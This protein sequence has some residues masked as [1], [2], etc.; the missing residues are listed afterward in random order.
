MRRW[1]KLRIILSA[2]LIRMTYVD[3]ELL[4]RYAI[5]LWGAECEKVWI[6]VRVDYLMRTFVCFVVVCVC[7]CALCKHYIHGTSPK[8][9]AV[10]ASSG[11]GSEQLAH[12]CSLYEQFY[13]LSSVMLSAWPLSLLHFHFN[14]STTQIFSLIHSSSRLKCQMGTSKRLR[15]SGKWVDCVHYLCAVCGIWGMVSILTGLTFIDA[16]SAD[17]KL[18]SFLS[19]LL[20]RWI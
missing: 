12:L 18:V 14:I 17:G 3:C 5:Y 9:K 13:C 16:N 15:H 8:H 11:P 20:Q 2:L 1:Q 7:V 6:C 4:W 19:L 10:C